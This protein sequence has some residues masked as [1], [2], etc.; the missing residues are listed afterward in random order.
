MAFYDQSEHTTGALA[1]RLSTEP[2]YLQELMGINIGTLLIA[3]INVVSSSTLSI[4]VGWK[5]GLVVLAGA[6]IPIVFCGYLRVRLEFLLDDCVLDRFADSAAL[7]SEAVSAIRTVASLAME[8]TVLHRYSEKL[9]GIEQRSL[10]FLVWTM[11]WLSLSQC[12]SLLSEALSFWYGGRLYSFGEYSSTQL[13]IIMTA[14]VLSGEGAASFFAFTT[15]ITKG[16]AACNY[17][18]WLRYLVPSVK[19]GGSPDAF[20]EQRDTAAHV[21]CEDLE[22]RYP[23]RPDRPVL[24]KINV[25]ILPGQVVAFVGPSGHGKSSLVSLLERYY[26]P[27][28]GCIKFDG[29]DISTVSLKSYRS[30]LALVQ[31][32]PTLYQG[33]IRENIALGLEKDATDDEILD[34]CRQANIYDFII[35]LP[36]GL[37]TACGSRGSLV[38]GGQRQR[39]AIAR[40]LIR[41]PR[42]LFLDEA[43]SALDTESERVVQAALDKAKEGRTTV[44]IAHRLS[45]IKDADQIF[46]LVDGRIVE[47][48]THDELLTIKG[49]YYD[50]CLGQALDRGI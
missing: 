21:E 7:A 15:S 37:A 28:S 24:Q 22:F 34:A 4:A 39:I 36:D 14:V 25:D 48:G 18:L 40:A 43:T 32:E 30:N 35:S 19:D 1:S 17:I 44:A 3:F 5:L 46:V 47:R 11:F 42:L 31:Q 27:V 13:Y 49:V 41:K 8:E 26:D 6:M 29:T 12:L 33:T 2:T 23:T 50:M 38:S 45:T 20:K 10:K 9:N 16:Q